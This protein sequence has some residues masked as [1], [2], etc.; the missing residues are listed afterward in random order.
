MKAT[1]TTTTVATSCVVP[2]DIELLT[3]RMYSAWSS[4][5]DCVCWRLVRF[6]SGLGGD[7]VEAGS[8]PFLQVY[9][10]PQTF[11]PKLQGRHV[12]HPN[13]ALTLIS[14]AVL[15]LEQRWCTLQ[16]QSS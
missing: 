16:L 7:L 2:L 12:Q 4:G 3:Y 5:P 8:R 1:V 10:A 6:D 14:P 9:R 11:K 13:I 15:F